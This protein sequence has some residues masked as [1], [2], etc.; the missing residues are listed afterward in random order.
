MKR[1]KVGDRVN[2]GCFGEAR[3]VEDRGDIGYGGRQIVRVAVA[4]DGRRR[5]EFEIPAAH[6]TKTRR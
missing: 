1:L 2:V 3:V 4:I 6:V 5:E